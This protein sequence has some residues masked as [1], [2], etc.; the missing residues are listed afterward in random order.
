MSLSTTRFRQWANRQLMRTGY[1]LIRTGAQPLQVTLESALHRLAGRAPQFRTVIDVGASDGRWSRQLAAVLPGKNFIMI[2]AQPIHHPGLE[3]Y[4]ACFPD[5][6]LIQAAAGRDGGELFFDASD[7]WGGVAA[8]SPHG[9][10][11][12]WIRVPA[13]TIDREVAASGFPGPYLIKLDTHGYE[14][15]ILEGASATL[16][17]TEV[18]VI[19]CYNFDVAPSAQ[20]F[21]QFCLQMERLGFRCID[22]FD[23]MHR[24][25]DGA[26]WQ[27]DLVFMKAGRPEFAV[28]RYDPPSA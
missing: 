23:P 17:S 24:P 13:T 25:A 28:N 2:E 3:R 16:G 14:T 20:R 26:L 15:P 12:S 10:T 4:K 8:E 9:S 7:P 18:L 21:P 6:R 11:G 19:E 1:R 5:T 27:M 22:L